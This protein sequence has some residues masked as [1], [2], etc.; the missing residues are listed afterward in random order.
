MTDILEEG[1]LKKHCKSCLWTHYQHSHISTAAIVLDQQKNKILLV[2]RAQEP[3][4]G[5]WSMP[6]GFCDLGEH[7]NDTIIREV[8]EETGL[9]VLDLRFL[10]M[11]IAYDDHRCPAQL[12]HYFH[13][14]VAPGKIS[15]D[16]KENLTVDW[17]TY[18]KLPKLAWET[19]VNVI[20]K[21]I[22]RLTG[23]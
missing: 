4:K 8:R 3:H 15:F 13:A 6:A 21:F 9:T 1:T 16:P 10:E 11:N 12:I 19:Q 22:R 2:Q 17:F 20:K 7:P 23:V 14:T 18:D 5:L